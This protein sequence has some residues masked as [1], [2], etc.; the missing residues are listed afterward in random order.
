LRKMAVRFEKGI[1]R[2]AE[3]RARWEGEPEKYVGLAFTI[4][5]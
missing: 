2:N 3:V 1:S 4:Y 5:I